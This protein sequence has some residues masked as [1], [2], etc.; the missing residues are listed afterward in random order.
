MSD[1]PKRVVLGTLAISPA[2]TDAVDG[3]L[4]DLER[5]VAAE[6]ERAQELSDAA[7]AKAGPHFAMAGAWAFVAAE[8]GRATVTFPE[9]A[10]VTWTGEPTP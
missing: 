5:D 1:D 6:P 7:V 3:I 4:A 9:G 2:T 10:T 8:A